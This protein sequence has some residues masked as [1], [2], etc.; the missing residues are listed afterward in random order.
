MIEQQGTSLL[1]RLEFI[2]QSQDNKY[3][4][5]SENICYKQLFFSE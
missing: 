2:H 3:I 5:L 4:D 1:L